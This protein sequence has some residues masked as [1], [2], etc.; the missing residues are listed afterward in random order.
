MSVGTIRSEPSVIIKVT[1]LAVKKSAAKKPPIV[2]VVSETGDHVEPPPPEVLETGPELSPLRM[3]LKN[4]QR[5]SFPDLPQITFHGLPGLLADALPDTFATVNGAS[6]DPSNIVIAGQQ[7][8]LEYGANFSGAGSDNV[9]ND[10][11]LVAVPEPSA[12]ALLSGIG[13]LLLLRPRRK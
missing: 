5:F 9:A 11:A 2:E 13:V 6:Y 4:R 8:E 12:T 10:V 1:T 3:K 7:F